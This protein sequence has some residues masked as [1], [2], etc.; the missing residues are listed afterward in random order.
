[1]LEVGDLVRYADAWHEAI[2][3]VVDRRHSHSGSENR[4][5]IRWLASPDN[6]HSEGVWLSQDWF[7]RHC[8]KLEV[9]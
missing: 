8:D 6:D 3:I 2:G 4:W 7:N 1:M 5:L 9:L